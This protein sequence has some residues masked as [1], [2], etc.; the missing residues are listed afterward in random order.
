MEG[1]R[2]GEERVQASAPPCSVSQTLSNKSQLFDMTCGGDREIGI[3][4][5]FTDMIMM[6]VN[7]VKL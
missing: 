5:T 3:S 7:V 2:E 4:I 1:K 6:G